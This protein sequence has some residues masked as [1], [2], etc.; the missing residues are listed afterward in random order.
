MDAAD[1]ASSWQLG[2][3]A[4]TFTTGSTA[5]PAAWSAALACS[6]LSWLLPIN[7]AACCSPMLLSRF[8][9]VVDNLPA[10][11]PEKYEKL[12]AILTKVPLQYLI[13]SVVLTCCGVW[14]C[15]TLCCVW[16]FRH[17]ASMHRSCFMRVGEAA[18]FAAACCAITRVRQPRAATSVL[19]GAAANAVAHSVLTSCSLLRCLLPATR[20]ADL[21]WQ[22]AHP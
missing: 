1:T 10:V 2:V 15:R 20:P 7:A 16:C 5:G 11:P 3:G 22:R 12:T 19:A 6:L 13:C 21:L 14:R 18:G 17:A 4:S 8:S 9:A